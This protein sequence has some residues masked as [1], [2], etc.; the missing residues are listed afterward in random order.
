MASGE[1]LESW[2]MFKNGWVVLIGSVVGVF[3]IIVGVLHLYL[4]FGPPAY[5]YPNKT[6]EAGGCVADDEKGNSVYKTYELTFSADGEKIQLNFDGHKE[7]LV[8]KGNDGFR[9]ETW[10]GPKFTYTA[11][12]EHSLFEKDGLYL[13]PACEPASNQAPP[14]TSQ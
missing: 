1:K 3:I 4:W 5:S 7:T 10:E 9:T 8:F 2:K 6:I 12:P 11:D 13:T 14:A